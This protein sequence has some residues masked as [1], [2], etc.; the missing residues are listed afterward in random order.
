MRAACIMYGIE[1]RCFQL[2][3]A[4]FGR[5]VAQAS[6]EGRR[7][8][9]ANRRRRLR[10]LCYGGLLDRERG[11]RLFGLI[12]KKGIACSGLLVFPQSSGSALRPFRLLSPAQPGIALRQQFKD[13]RIVRL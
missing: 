1:T 9:S 12:T 6:R 2:V 8:D 3:P 5:A 7:H 11:A 4:D 13:L 10:R